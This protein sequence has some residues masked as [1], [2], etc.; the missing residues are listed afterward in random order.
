MRFVAGSHHSV[1]SVFRAA[2][3]LREFLA[4]AAETEEA[5]ACSW[6]GRSISSLASWPACAS[7]RVPAAKVVRQTYGITAYDDNA[8]L[9]KSQVAT[10]RI[11]PVESTSP[12]VSL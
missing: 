9:G 11:P 10:K 5:K 3:P 8:N 1:K 6:T 2:R 4:K 12:T 7:I